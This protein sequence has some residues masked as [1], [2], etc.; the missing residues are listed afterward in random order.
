MDLYLELGNEDIQERTR[1]K[2]SNRIVVPV[3][4][5]V[6]L[7]VGGT[8][9]VPV[10]TQPAFATQSQYPSEEKDDDEE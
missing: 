4:I 10:I 6:I 5:A 2:S 7:I 8:A 1:L 9:V 3:I